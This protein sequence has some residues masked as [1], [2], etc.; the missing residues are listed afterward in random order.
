MSQFQHLFQP[1]QVGPM[2]VANRICET[3]NT[4]NSSMVPGGIDDHFIAHHLAKA[5]GGAAWIGS[6][7][8]LLNS[9]F[10]P[11][12]PDEV[13][14][15]VGF[16]SHF[17][18]WQ[19][20]PFAEGMQKFYG[21]LHEVG[22]V[23]IA[24]LT[25]LS[26]VWAPSAVPPVGAQDYV[27][28]V[29]G[30]D[31]IEF[32]FESYAQAAEAAKRFGA[33]GIEMH[34]AHETLGYTFLSPVTN[35]RTDRWGGGPQERI[36]FVVEALRRI[37]AKVGND[38]GLGIRISGKEFRQGGYDNLEM[39]EMLY[40]VGETGLLDFVD[41]DVG[42]CWGAPSYVPNSYYGHGQFREYGKAA[43]VDLESQEKRI[44]VLFSGRVNDP[45]VAEELVRDGYCDLVGMVR[46]GIADPEFANKARE[47]RLSEIRRCISCTRCIDEASE[48][49]TYP[50]T[51][52]CSI[53]PVIGN[54]LKWEQTYKP[55][56]EPRR[57][58]VVGGGLA[59][60]EAARVAAMR[61][62]RVTLLE[63]GKR[64]GG[65]LLLAMATPGRDDFE[66]QVYFEEN[67]MERLGV[68]VRLEANAD[69]A[70]IK[71]MAPDA[72]VVATGSVPRVP[73]GIPG[74]DLPHVVQCW[75]VLGGRAT[76]GNRVAVIS[77]EDYYE[78]PCVAEYLADKGKHVEIFTKSVH[79]GF[80]IARYS[81]GMV[82]RRMEECGVAIHPNLVLKAVMPDALELRSSFGE[83]TYRK[84][85]FDTVVLV[86]G[87]VPRPDLYEELKA[88]G[89]I[90]QLF[91]AGSAW[92]PRFMAEA[93]RHGASIGLVL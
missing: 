16:A 3:T 28:H 89:S 54:E 56:D 26:A 5:K 52:T 57:I 50:Y 73:A 58:V 11:E 9:P 72:V 10:P 12:T 43:K 64:L 38:L 1:I 40:Y 17:P 75:D 79:L 47:G 30:E 83:T 45:V 18:I 85:G 74:I 42:H 7:T 41:I 23:A 82:L 46:A 92:L 22:A 33:D 48:P 37:R 44:A 66:D 49:R 55:A 53:N 90:P 93:A 86:Y 32:H 60:T 81:V 4:I 34:C 13:G 59:G 51:P 35:R 69:A 68:E 65:Q 62:H 77:Q 91:V 21:A 24:Q 8:W 29:M 15:S 20:P 25:H 87:S 88:D 61:G 70:S 2:R 80:E 36:R 78:T 71:A 84:E 39:R 76:V 67:E 31:E 14:L 19:N 6:E 63:R 27:P